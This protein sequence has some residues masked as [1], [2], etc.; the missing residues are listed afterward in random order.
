M[1]PNCEEGLVS[2]IVP[3]FNRRQFLIEC[4]E[5]VKKQTY[6]PIELLVVDD[7]STD[8]TQ[9]ILCEWAKGIAASEKL[10]VVN[11]V[12]PQSGA[13]VARNRGLA[14]SHGQFIQMLDDDDA[15]VA[16]KIK[17]DLSLLQASKADFAYSAVL[18][19]DKDGRSMGSRI[20]CVWTGAET[21]V[22]DYLWQTMGPIYKRDMVIKLGPWLEDLTDCQDWEYSARVK[23]LGFRGVFRD[24]VGGLFRDH[25]VGK[26]ITKKRQI[27][28]IHSY[29]MAYRS[30]LSAA[31]AHNRLSRVVRE[32]LARRFISVALL[33]G[34]V[35]MMAE[36]RSCLLT[37]RQLVSAG[38][39][40][41]WGG[42]VL[43]VCHSREVDRRL[44]RLLM[45]AAQYDPPV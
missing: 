29:E 28:R 5:S 12:Q 41:W 45:P 21:E 23:L 10:S 8:D 35:G 37:A 18:Q 25:T 44:V 33:H 2:V 43:L 38:S 34:S 24:A 1:S 30:A 40:T 31:E 9:A 22:V 7:G 26:E 13:Q 39:K 20:G 4:L 3:T 14:Y 19:V 36:R 11:I 16:D 42:F 32:R 17:E 15:L 6:R 27:K